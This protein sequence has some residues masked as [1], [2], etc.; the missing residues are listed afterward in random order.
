MTNLAALENEL[1]TAISAAPDE[2]ALEA[3][4]VAAL[5]RNGSISALL[6]TLG[7]LPP[8]ERKERGAAINAVKD[9]VTAAIAARKDALKEQALDQRLHRAAQRHLSPAGRPAARITRAGRPGLQP[10]L[11]FP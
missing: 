2:G 7:T 11:R 10:A 9:R 1:Q 6:K 4:R 3:V 5:G 8:D